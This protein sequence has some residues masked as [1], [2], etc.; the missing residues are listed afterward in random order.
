MGS[1]F[2][3]KGLSIQRKALF[4]SSRN[5]QELGCGVGLRGTFLK[6]HRRIISKNSRQKKRPHTIRV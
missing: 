2:C 6:W 5:S 3:S 4:L 1:K